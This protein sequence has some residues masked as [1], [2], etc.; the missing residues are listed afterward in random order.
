MTSP[1][2]G[3]TTYQRDSAGNRTQQTDAR[4][5]VTNY[6]YDALNRMATMQFPGNTAENVTYT[7]DSVTG[8]NIG[9]GRLTSLTDQSG[10]TTFVYDDRGNVVTETRTIN[11][12]TYTTT[13]AYNLADNLLQVTYPS[14]RVVT[15]QRDTLGRV[16]AVTT[17]ISSSGAPVLLANNITYHP[18][19]PITSLTYGNGLGLTLTYDQDYRLTD[20]R[21]ADG[22]TVIQVLDYVYDQADN[23][24][25]I[26]DVLNS[27]RNQTLGYDELHRLTSPTGLYGTLGYTYDAVG[28]RLT[29]TSGGNTD[30]YTYATTSNQLLSILSGSNTR[31]FTYTTNGQISGDNRGTGE[32]FGLNYN[33]QNRLNQI[34]KNST[35]TTEY[36]HNAL[37]Q[38]VVKDDL[39]STTDSHYHYDR[40]GRLLAESDPQGVMTKEYIHLDGL[41]L[42][43]I[44]TGSTGSGPILDLILDNSDTEVTTNGTWTTATEG[45]GYEGTD[46]LEHSQSGVPPG[47]ELIDNESAGFST[48]GTWPSSTTG[49]GYEGTNYVVRDPN[50]IPADIIVDN[51]DATFSTTGSWTASTNIP[52]YY[53]SNY[54][55]HHP[56]QFSP[57][58][59]TLDN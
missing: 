29:R 28:N 11:T 5:V 33:H 8:G 18:F 25:S 34:T 27:T 41:P 57:D 32:N 14:G 55:W 58:A 23:I 17:Q 19:G 51:A 48:V 30:T 54:L 31:P 59:I 49:T 39:A 47:G 24:T 56:Y 40:D 16:I 38:R 53:A 12:Q 36:L 44:D 45:T 52:G 20:I 43:V 46:Y 4:G 22:A 1:D 3:T 15:Y 21:T 6:T 2:T 9:K 50:A 26:T 42:A 13:Y 35:A 10:S 37:G 7:Y